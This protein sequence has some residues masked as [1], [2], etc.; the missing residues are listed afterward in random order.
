MAHHSRQWT[1]TS[2]NYLVTAVK[3]STAARD[4]PQRHTTEDH[5]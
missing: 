3:A 1:I 2:V 5:D 4:I